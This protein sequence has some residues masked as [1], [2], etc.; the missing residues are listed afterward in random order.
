MLSLFI[1]ELVDRFQ[2]AAIDQA[3]EEAWLVR[4]ECCQHVN[5]HIYRGKERRIKGGW[6]GFFGVNHFHYIRL[7]F[8]GDS[9]LINTFGRLL[10]EHQ[11]AKLADGD[12]LVLECAFPD[13]SQLKD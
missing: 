9:H 5:P 7:T 1:V 4:G 8:G 3:W 2:G 13:G 6:L 10:R 11:K 12:F